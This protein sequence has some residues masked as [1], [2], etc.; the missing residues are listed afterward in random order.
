MKLRSAFKLEFFPV[1]GDIGPPSQK[2]T[3]C[4]VVGSGARLR[5]NVPAR[6]DA[7]VVIT[8]ARSREGATRLAVVHQERL[9]PLTQYLGVAHSR[10]VVRTA[11]LESLAMLADI[12]FFEN[13]IVDEGLQ[14]LAQ[15][16]LRDP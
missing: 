7:T 16:V 10:R 5:S 8:H 13:L 1:P 2:A 11:I 15:D 4:N 14:A 9:V 6:H 12:S 3:L